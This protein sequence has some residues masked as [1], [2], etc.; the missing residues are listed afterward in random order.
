MLV[1]LCVIP[2]VG[3]SRVPVSM[4][5]VRYVLTPKKQLGMNHV[6]EHTTTGFE[7]SK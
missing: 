1:S 6:V 7:I 3:V 4:F 5:S 2:L